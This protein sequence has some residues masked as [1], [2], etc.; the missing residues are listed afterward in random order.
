MLLFK[1]RP[2]RGVF[3]VGAK[4][5]E[6]T[7]GGGLAGKQCRLPAFG[8]R[9]RARERG[10]G[11]RLY[12]A[13]ELGLLLGEADLRLVDLLLLQ[14]NPNH[15]QDQVLAASHR[16]LCETGNGARHPTARGRSPSAPEQPET[17]VRTSATRARLVFKAHR[18]LHHATPSSR[19]IQKKT[20]R[21]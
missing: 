18:L 7:E 2:R 20:Q 3:R 9:E 19:A 12:L 16:L 5:C 14:S 11:A 4:K 21:C 10:E 17:T 6:V 15:R 13:L 8:E 1:I